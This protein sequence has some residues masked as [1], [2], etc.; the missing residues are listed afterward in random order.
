[1]VTFL[2]RISLLAELLGYAALGTWLRLAHGWEIARIVAAAVAFSLLARLALVV[3]SSLHGWFHRTPRAPGHRLGPIGTLRLVASEYAAVVANNYVRL[4]FEPL[5]VRPDPRPAAGTGTPVILLHGYLSNRSFFLPMLKWLESR[6]VA[7]VFLPNYKSV[8]SDI[9]R[10]VQALHEA[11]ERIAGGVG[12][13]VVLVCHSM[14]GLIARRYLQQHGEAR[15]LRLVTIASP[16]HGTAMA[17]LGFGP[18]ARQMERGSAFLEAI[19]RTEAAS[20]PTVPTL[21][22]YSAHDNL[23][24]PQD[25]S[26]LPWARN[27]ALAGVG[28]VGILASHEAFELVLAE[29]RAAGVAAAG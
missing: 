10:G 5:L 7:P 19:S 4:P 27:V 25:T 18:H 2:V 20:A 22:I 17:R 6:G 13:Q 8:F 15:I 9:D 1:V 26:R 12:Q 3:F 28:H 11:V 23:V 16:H 21:S 24:S 29:L 14:G